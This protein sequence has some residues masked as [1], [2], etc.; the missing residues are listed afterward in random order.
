MQY[1]ISMMTEKF[2]LVIDEQ[3][4]IPP[5]Q[6]TPVFLTSLKYVGS[7]PYQ[8]G[9]EYAEATLHFPRLT[10]AIGC[11]G[12]GNREQLPL[13]DDENSGPGDGIELS[14]GELSPP[15]AT[16]SLNP[17]GLGKRATSLVRRGQVVSIDMF[18]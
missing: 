12:C 17:S 1:N 5:T 4:Y 7:H 15:P 11:R 9:R 10:E 8:S 18:P 3:Q 6:N 2:G 13:P 14:H 16:A